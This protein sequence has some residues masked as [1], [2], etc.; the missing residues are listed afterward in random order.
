MRCDT[1]EEVD[2]SAGDSA[3]DIDQVQLLEMK[4][5]IKESK[6]FVDVA[7][8]GSPIS[9]SKYLIKKCSVRNKRTEVDEQIESDDEIQILEPNPRK[10]T[11]T[12]G[13]RC[14]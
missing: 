12:P 13:N 8:P 11:F 6:N 4:Q 14:S 5:P 10:L 7:K 1:L 3:Q 9:P 2:G